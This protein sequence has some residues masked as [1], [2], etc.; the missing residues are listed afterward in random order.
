MRR[1]ATLS[2]ALVAGLVLAGCGSGPSQVTS[3]AIV[4]DRSVPLDDVQQEIRW[5]LDNVPQAEQAKQQRKLDLQAREVVR[6]RVAHELTAIA[7][8]REGLR[9]DPAQVTELV[10]TSGGAEAIARSVGVEPGRVR[11]IATDQIL[12]QQL[13]QR[14]LDRLTVSLIGTT[15]VTESA[16]ST[17]KEQAME[18]GRRIAEQPDQVRR[19]VRQSGHEVL[20][21]DLPLADVIQTQPEVAASAIFGAAEGTVL[22]IQPSRQQTGWLVALVEDRRVAARGDRSAATRTSPEYLYFTGLRLLQPIAEEVGVR[23]N[24][25]YGV[26]DETA[27]APAANEDEVSGYQLRSRTVQP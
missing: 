19:I 14:Y 9:A 15:I 2:V 26:W 21:A 11:E 12:L 17:A 13:A 5:L 25:R 23:I 1:A 6:S 27:L 10:E 7:A 4:G 24:P 22:V 8:E 18:L 20:D 3:A 16:G